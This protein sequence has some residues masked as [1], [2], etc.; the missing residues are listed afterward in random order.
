VSPAAIGGSR[1]RYNQYRNCAA[2]GADDGVECGIL[3]GYDYV[4]VCVFIVS[5]TK[6]RM[7]RSLSTPLVLCMATFKASFVVAEIVGRKGEINMKEEH[8][9]A[10]EH[11]ESAA[12]SHRAAADAHGKN[13]HTKGKEHSTQAQ[14]HAQN[15]QQHSKIANDKS[16]QQK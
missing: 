7:P 11:H 1:S 9:K 3:N 6:F 5:G 2:A 4:V 12:K 15:A 14:Q 13:D 10:A 16:Q 8:N